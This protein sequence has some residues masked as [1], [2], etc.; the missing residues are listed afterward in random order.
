MDKDQL[1]ALFTEQTAGL[2][3]EETFEAIETAFTQRVQLQ[4]EAALEQQDAVMAEK[5]EKLLKAIDKDSTYK[6]KRVVESIDTN[7]TNKLKKLAK[8]YNKVINEDANKFKGDLIRSISLYLETY[9]DKAIPAE[10]V[11]E[12]V[13]NK[14]AVKVLEN[15]RNILAVD[16]ALSKDSIRGAIADGKTKIDALT[17]QVKKIETEKKLLSEQLENTKREVLLEQKTAN[18]PA[19][20]KD[21]IKRVLGDKSVEFI[22]E[23][24]EYTVTLLEKKKRQ[25][26]TVLKEQAL[27]NV[28]TGADAP[29]PAPKKEASSVDMYI[30][31]LDRLF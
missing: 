8:H 28:K 31:E 14:T 21:Y 19:A 18:M 26:A 13:K 5:L 12:A 16:N 9:I 6:L 24:F 1:K 29:V 17:E 30:S 7:N 2:L 4:V 15:L 3:S 20:K 10:A 11:T 23:N 27:R 25:E 22:N